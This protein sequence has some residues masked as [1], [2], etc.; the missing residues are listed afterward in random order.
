[1]ESVGVFLITDEDVVWLGGELYQALVPLADGQRSQEDI[2]A[3]LEPRYTAAKVYYAL[4]RLTQKGCLVEAAPGIPPAEAEYWNGLGVDAASGARA[5]ASSRVSL[6]RAGNAPP[7]AILEEAL[8]AAGIPLV[9][10]GAGLALVVTD[11]YLRPS[12]AELNQE[13]L[14]SGRPWVLARLMGKVAWLGPYFV[15]G[16]TACWECL[17]QRLR[18]NRL[19]FKF[20]EERRAQGFLPQPGRG[21]CESSV[22]AAAS[23]LAMA[24][25]RGLV[26]GKSGLEDVLVTLDMMALRTEHHTVV[27]RPQCPACGNPRLME[28]RQL[29]PLQLESQRKRFTQDG[30]HRLTSPEETLRLHQHHV[31]RLTGVVQQLKPIHTGQGELAPLI[32]SGPNFARRSQELELL[33]RT[34]RNRSTGKGKTWAQARASGLCEAIERYCGVFQGDEA[35]RWDTFRGLGEEALHPQ[36]LLGFSERQ[37]RIREQWNATSASRIHWVPH[38]FDEGQRVEWSPV[39]SLTQ[40]RMR[41]VPTACCYY[42]YSDGAPAFCWADSNGCAAGN[43]L[44]E[45]ILQGFLELAE[46]DAVALWWYNRVRRPRVRLED[47]DEPYCHELAKSYQRLGREFWVLDLTTD[48]GIP[49]FAA[50]SRDVTRTPERIS[51]GFGAHLEARIGILRALTEMNQFLPL[52]E[53]AAAGAS[54]GESEFTRWLETAT[55][56]QH[57]YLAP[58][59]GALA[60]TAAYLARPGSEDLRED[61]ERCVGMARRLG[62]ETLVLDQT[63]PDVG[64]PVARV[65][66]PGL[67]HMWPRLGPG[68]LYDVPVRLGWLSQPTPEE[69]LNPVGIFI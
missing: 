55:L 10:H 41:Y 65:I 4:E 9:E 6:V 62:L 33:R 35:R 48:L 39:W 59:E 28:E 16:K 51:M 8:A 13:A 69:Q 31:N 63:R 11:D 27:R 17:A 7:D 67:R 2:V 34:L 18:T 68:R 29:R 22:R 52:L 45:A 43:S 23:L 5:L 25:V 44:E 53:L 36:R 40:R 42:G 58:A 12:L 21:S 54:P 49:S 30:G 37:Y 46:R 66:V 24:M 50:I 57:P 47:F 32:D 60:D 26:T 15:P 38:P 20:I 56:A 14:R 61:V 19:V 64:L 3:A 1:M